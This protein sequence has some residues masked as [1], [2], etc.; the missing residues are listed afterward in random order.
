MFRRLLAVGLLAVCATAFTAAASA[1]GTPPKL[2]GTAAPAP[3]T[4]PNAAADID[5]LIKTLDDPAARDKLKQQLQLLLDAQ[6]GK[7][8]PAGTATP[9]PEAPAEQ[10]VGAKMLAVVSHH[11]NA[12]SN[13]LVNLVEVIA[14]VPQRA[15][16]AAVILADPM[17]RAYWI[18]VAV[19]VFGV[20]TTAFIAAWAARR[21]MLRPR[22]ALQERNTTRWLVRLAYLPLIFVVE[23]LSTLAFAVASSVTLPLFRPNEYAA[24]V[25]LTIIGAQIATMLTASTTASLL[26]VSAPRLR[27][28]PMS[29]ETAPISRSG[30]GAWRWSRSTA[31]RSP[32][33]RPSSAS[34]PRSMK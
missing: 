2:P 5:G 4:K 3:A 31:M 19:D 20:L 23:A 34:M 33:S 13:A 12:I 14:D 25:T 16:Q 32:S 22:R 8:N 30:C 7:T 1:Q 6:N 29:D 18:D 15:Q 17:R 9:A 26:A 24:D 27:L 10:G 28:F 21:L 11:V